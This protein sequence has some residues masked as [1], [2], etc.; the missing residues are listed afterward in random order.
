MKIDLESLCKNCGRCCAVKETNNG[1]IV[2]SEKYCPHLQE[3]GDGSKKTFCDIYGHHIGSSFE[4]DGK[5][6]RCISAKDSFKQGGL[7]E[8]CPYVAYYLCHP[9]E[10]G[11]MPE[12]EFRKRKMNAFMIYE[13]ACITQ[14]WLKI[15]PGPKANCQHCYGRGY[16]GRDV[17]SNTHV[18]CRC[19]NR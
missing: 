18:L 6:H 9:E 3:W 10:L 8:D 14:D 19:V 4:M 7:P 15:T 16:E 17:K 13:G 2:F 12:E 1:K 5:T 11:I